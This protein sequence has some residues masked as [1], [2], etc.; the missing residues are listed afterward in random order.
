MDKHLTPGIS[1]VLT[2]ATGMVGE[3]VLIECLQHRA[4]EQVLVINR[5]S[6]GIS[7]PKLE[8][9]IH[10][11]F[12]DLSPIEDQLVGYNACF[13]CAGISSMGMKEA[14]YYHLTYELTLHVAKTL[15]KLNSDM[16]FCYVSGAG[17]D[18]T[19]K[20]RIMWA[21]IK[22]KTENELM[23]LPFK[24]VYNFR[25]GVLEPTIG[26]KNTKYYNYIG[27]LIPVVRKLA[28]KYICTLKQLSIAMIN[29]V[30]KGYEKPIL[31]VP[32]IKTLANR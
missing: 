26:M 4:V 14:D 1:V 22:G 24:S 8:E 10:N 7:N 18:S 6:C 13:F 12:Y 19:E 25:P 5:R 32:D 9:I 11:N 30:T 15:S 28:P 21:R 16:M 2:G 29:A 31:E 17:T 3:G 27:W 23:K 20:G